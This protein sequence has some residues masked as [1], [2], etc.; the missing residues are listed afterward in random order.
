MYFKVRCQISFPIYYPAIYMPQKEIPRCACN[1]ILKVISGGETA[2][3]TG[4]VA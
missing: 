1:E 4:D 2:G 3:P